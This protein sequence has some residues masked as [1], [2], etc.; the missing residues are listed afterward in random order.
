[1]PTRPGSGLNANWR[2]QESLLSGAARLLGP[3]NVAHGAQK[4]LILTGPAP[5]TVQGGRGCRQGRDSQGPGCGNGRL[6]VFN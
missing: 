3:D 4:R 5:D 1:M 6:G 2:W